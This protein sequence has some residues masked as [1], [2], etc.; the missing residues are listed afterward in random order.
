MPYNA[1]IDLTDKASSP[2]I[3]QLTYLAPGGFR[4]LIDWKKYSNVE[5]TV[6]QVALPEITVNAAPLNLKQR[7]IGLAPDKIE[8]GILDVSFLIDENM[9]NYQEIH[10]W[11]LGMVTEEDNAVNK[12]TRDITLQVLSSANNIVRTIRFIDAFPI[13][14]SSIPFDT[15]RADVEYVVGNIQFQYSYFKFA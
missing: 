6:Q 5:Y 13:S 9:V 15:T 11:M 8:Y 12:K 7:N 1:N 14:L 2:K 3:N 4:L 10:D